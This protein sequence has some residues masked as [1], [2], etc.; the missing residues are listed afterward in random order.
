MMGGLFVPPPGPLHKPF[1]QTAPIVG[2][3]FVT[4]HTWLWARMWRD[5]TIQFIERGV[6]R[7]GLSYRTVVYSWFLWMFIW[8]WTELK[9]PSVRFLGFRSSDRVQWIVH[10]GNLI[11]EF[12]FEFKLKLISI[13]VVKISTEVTYSNNWLIS[14]LFLNTHN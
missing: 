6:E 4:T 2:T 10:I 8:G 7:L 14:N 11:G 3:Q 9:L 13:W 1:P 5:Q 12:K